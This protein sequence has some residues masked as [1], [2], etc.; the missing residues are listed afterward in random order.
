MQLGDFGGGRKSR[1]T[2]RKNFRPLLVNTISVEDLTGVAPRLSMT[3]MNTLNSDVFNTLDLFS[4]CG[5]M[6][7]GLGLASHPSGSSIRCSAA[8]DNWKV[9]CNTFSRNI[10]VEP[11]CANIERN[12]IR[13]L[14]RTSG[15]F[16]I[17]VGGPPCQGFSTSGKR[18]LDDPRNSLVVSFLEAVDVCRPRAF[19]MENVTG[20]STYQDGNLMS[21]VLDRAQSLGYSTHPGIVLASLMGVPQR[22]RRFIL[23]GILD[24]E[25]SFP[26]SRANSDGVR[27]LSLDGLDDL[28]QATLVAN[29]RPEDGTEAWTFDDATSDLPSLKV[30]ESSKTYTSTPKND[31]QR[32]CRAESGPELQDHIAVNHKDYMVEMMKHIPPGESALDESVQAEMPSELRPTSGFKN[33]YGRIHGSLPSPTIT[34]NFTCPSSANCIHPKDHRAMSI[35]E[36]ARCQSFP[37]H[38]TFH[39]SLSDKRLQIGNAVPPLLAKALGGALLDSLCSD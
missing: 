39:G 21:E 16:S 12:S 8:M 18:S 33:S 27:Q 6:A 31:Y 3:F 11:I 23:V 9:A 15:P 25:F 14:Q 17:V 5:G 34:R 35:R 1:F 2:H 10:G 32:W 7:F 37:D 13:D 19:L 20:F 38:F 4:G 29:M 22:R 36:G 24:G 30:G 26:I 28:E